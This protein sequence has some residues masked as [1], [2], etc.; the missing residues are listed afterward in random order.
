LWPDAEYEN[1]ELYWCEVIVSLITDC[2][3]ELIVELPERNCGT[4]GVARVL[5]GNANKTSQKSLV[6]FY[7]NGSRGDATCTR[8]PSNTSR[9]SRR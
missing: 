6:N 7:A 3:V 2:E 4:I 1:P 8:S 5:I 9:N